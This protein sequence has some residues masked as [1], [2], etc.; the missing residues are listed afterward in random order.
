LIEVAANGSGHHANRSLESLLHELAATIK[1]RRAER[2]FFIEL[3]G[4]PRAGKTTLLTALAD[5]LRQ[6][7]LRV[8]TVD[9]SATGCPIPDK[10]DPSFNFWTFLA[11]LL[12]ILE[13]QSDDTDVVVIDRGIV[14]AACWTDW[15]RVTGCLTEDEHRTIEEFMLL[16]R[17]TRALNLVLVMTTEPAVA[18]ERE[19]AEG[20]RRGR[21]QIV[22]PD[23]LG[24]FN[25][26]I[27]RVRARF[28]QRYPLVR[29]DT[30]QLAPDAVMHRLIAAALERWPSVNSA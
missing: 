18:V 4:T 17:W 12:Q 13:A 5:A 3:A 27:D 29:V 15:H 20:G 8:D 7:G 23:T 6:R 30:T 19:A 28:D 16:P 14:D 9:R 11:T 26:S 22:N 10:R 2:P 21:G 1:R 25:E 24:A